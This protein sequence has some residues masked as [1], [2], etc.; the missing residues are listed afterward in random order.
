MD[1]SMAVNMMTLKSIR[2]WRLN[3]KLAI[4]KTVAFLLLVLFCRILLSKGTCLSD[5][6]VFKFMDLAKNSMLCE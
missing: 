1:R 6:K 4:I 3:F 2:T 5:H